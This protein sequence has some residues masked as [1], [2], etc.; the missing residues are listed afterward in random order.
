MRYDKIKARKRWESTQ[1]KK[2][3]MEHMAR[4]CT[5]YPGP[6]EIIEEV[7]VDGELVPVRKPYVRKIYRSSHAQRYSYYK[8]Y[9]NRAVR[10]YSKKSYIGNGNSYRRIFDYQWEID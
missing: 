2:K 3:R 7:Y 8:K 9:S 4:T 1:R 10:R 6:A 5:S